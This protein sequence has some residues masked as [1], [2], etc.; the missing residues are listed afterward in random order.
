MWSIPGLHDFGVKHLRI[1]SFV[2]CTLHTVDLGPLQKWIAKGI[3]IVLDS[4]ALQTQGRTQADRRAVG[5][6]ALRA[7]LK[8]YYRTLRDENPLRS[9]SHIKKLTVGMLG[10]FQNPTLSANAGESRDL[11]GFV[12][13]LLAEFSIQLGDQGQ[14]LQGAGAALADFYTITR[15]SP[16]SMSVPDQNALMSCV[17]RHNSLARAAGIKLVPKH[18]SWVHMVFAC[19][20][21]GNPSKYSTFEDES[22]NG[23]I[24]RIAFRVHPHTFSASVFRRISMM[25]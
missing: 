1:D 14:L 10:K 6:L 18:H 21:Q 23:A 24:A 13:G 22:E 5:M 20:R 7:R 25:I 19:K 16:R 11:V 2:D 15:D 9:V 3:A 8:P 12:N 4:D 17:L